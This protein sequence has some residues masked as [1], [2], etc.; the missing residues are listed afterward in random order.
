MSLLRRIPGQYL[1]PL[2][3]LVGLCFGS[4]LALL[5]VTTSS[6][7]RMEAAREARTLTAALRTN[8]DMVRRDLQDYA[9]WDDA[10]RHI[11]RDFDADW[12]DD[13]VTAYL[14]RT[15]GYDHVFV[16]APDGST[17]YAF[18]HGSLSRAS[19][20]KG[21]TELFGP[22]FAESIAAVRRM[23]PAHSPSISGFT[24]QGDH[25]Y[26]YAVAAVVPLTHKV[27]LPPGGKYVLAIANEVDGSFLTRLRKAHQLVGLTVRQDRGAV[28]LT[29]FRG[30]TLAH[31]DLAVRTPGSRLRDQILP[32]LI[33]II[34]LSALVAASVVRQGGQAMDALRSSRAD[35]VHNA[36]H[37]P[38]TALPNR[39][40]LL[41]RVRVRLLDGRAVGLIYM[42]LD[43]FK[44]VNDLYG[45]RA[46]DDL[47]R[48]ATVRIATLAGE[49]ALVAR[50]GG[51]EFAV[52]AAD[53]RGH[54]ASALAQRIIDG[55]QETFAISGANVRVGVSI[56]VVT[57]PRHCALTVDE[58][59]RRADVAM[60]SAKGRGKNRWHLYA[61]GMDTG[62]DVRKRLEHD[63][64]TA[65]AANGIDV[66]YQPIVSAATGRI[67]CFEAL[68][69]WTHPREGMIPPD[70]FIPL[71]EMTGLIGALGEQV[72]AKACRAVA[73]FD[74]GLAVN[75]SPA[76]FWDAHLVDS[77]ARIL[78]EEAFP[79]DRLELEIT[80]NYL[81]RRPDAAAGVMEELRTL[82]IRLAL[83]DFGSGFAS[84]GYLRQLKFDRLKIDKQFVS[85]AAASGDVGEG[86]AEMLV[87]I[88]ALGRAL[89]LE[90]TAEGVETQDQSALVK[91]C[92]CH[93]MQGWLHGRP[94]APEM[95]AE[96]VARLGR[97]G[98]SE[99]GGDGGQGDNLPLRNRAQG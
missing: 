76:Q 30:R 31:V 71:A 88:V 75:L 57:T 63:L 62:H 8:V 26:I 89:R 2:L 70:V 81:M 33:L 49:D 91:A 5:Y 11:A 66:A 14:G 59:M 60:Y 64:R 10:V 43:G 16:I 65:I 28:P 67:V 98:D 29:D 6:Q 97:D 35:A 23:D 17:P 51:D 54:D 55:F 1:W 87:A 85:D 40:V 13:N 24:R 58:L 15:Q 53:G 99:R 86:A 25:F 45:H 84:I 68:A 37:D 20:G 94:V 72:L 52:L 7:D 95:L 44:E 42:D 9:M 21:A 82:G 83:D 56:G 3:A 22:A 27:T 39:R 74:I 38:L 34:L 92:G 69:R 80:E 77:V 93:R 18:S 96:T 79:A 36:D 61:A 90:I 47:L 41:E 50:M 32:G 46:G 73:P 4:I 78:K 19:A 48:A 12:I